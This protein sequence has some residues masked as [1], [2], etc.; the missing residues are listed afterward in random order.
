MPIEDILNEIVRQLAFQTEFLERIAI[1]LED[2]PAQP[3]KA[4]AI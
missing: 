1:A 2:I 4:R 3:N